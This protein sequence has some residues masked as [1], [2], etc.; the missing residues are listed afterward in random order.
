VLI[1]RREISEIRLAWKEEIDGISFRVQLKEVEQG[2][3][4]CVVVCALVL[5]VEKLHWK[6]FLALTS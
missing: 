5:V 1:F 3:H 4:R 2:L 6:P